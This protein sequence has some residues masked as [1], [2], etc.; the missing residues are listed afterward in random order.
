MAIH[1]SILAW[2]IPRTEEPDRLQSIGLQSFGQNLATKQQNNKC[3][4]LFAA[5]I[6]IR[7]KIGGGSS[8]GRWTVLS[9]SKR[10]EGREARKEEEMVPQLVWQRRSLSSFQ[11]RAWHFAI[12]PARLMLELPKWP[13][14]PCPAVPR[15]FYTPNPDITA[16]EIKIQCK[17]QALLTVKVNDT[18][19]GC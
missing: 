8:E 16:R 10:K 2:R 13:S 12:L 3:S 4:K 19:T 5:V 15:R 18:E 1:F 17:I 6:I 9:F 7:T 14:P 11:K